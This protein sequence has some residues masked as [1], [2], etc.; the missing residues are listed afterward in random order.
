MQRFSIVDRFFHVGYTVAYRMMRVYWA[1]RRPR[2]HGALV[3][4]W[5]DGKILLVRN[6]YHDYYSLPGGYVRTGESGLEAAK[7]ELK[8]EIGLDLSGD[9]LH[10]SLDLEHIWES[11]RERLELFCMEC[12]RAPTIEVD[13]REVLSAEYFEPER[14]LKLSMFPPIRRHILERTAAVAG[15]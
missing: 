5:H 6:S 2:T 3:A 15:I 7:R 14:A 4:V 8:E 10:R 11:K 1:I 9:Q 12:D 13:G